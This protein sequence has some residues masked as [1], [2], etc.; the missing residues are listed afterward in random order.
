[1]G[2]T[3]LGE[4]IMIRR[5]KSDNRLPPC[6][7]VAVDEAPGILRPL[8]RAANAKTGFRSPGLRLGLPSVARFAG[9]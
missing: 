7:S 3:S 6:A 8:K 4:Y 9:L 5:V 2:T 1:M